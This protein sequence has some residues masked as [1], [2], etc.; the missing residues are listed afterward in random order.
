LAIEEP[1]SPAR[2]DLA[3]NERASARIVLGL[4]I[5]CMLISTTYGHVYFVTIQALSRSVCFARSEVS[6]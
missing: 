1:Y 2:R 6:G 4:S 5:L 3:V